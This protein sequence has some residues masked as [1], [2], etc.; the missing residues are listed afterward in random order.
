MISTRILGMNGEEARCKMRGS[1]WSVALGIIF[2][3]VGLMVSRAEIMYAK[4]RA[5]TPTEFGVPI[6]TLGVILFIIG[7]LVEFF[8]IGTAVRK[9]ASKT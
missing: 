8:Q 4:E 1:I 3:V 5:I 7:I 6:A 2:A 9:I